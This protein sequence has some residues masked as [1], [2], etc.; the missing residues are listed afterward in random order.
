MVTTDKAAPPLLP[1][2]RDDQ[3][4]GDYFKTT[5]LLARFSSRVVVAPNLLVLMVRGG[6]TPDGF[7]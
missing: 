5:L 6:G 1:K 3:V 7:I 2:Q 4:T